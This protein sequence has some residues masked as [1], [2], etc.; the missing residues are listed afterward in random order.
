M[1]FSVPQLDAWSEATTQSAAATPYD[2]VAAPLRSAYDVGP[3]PT[4]SEFAGAAGVIRRQAPGLVWPWVFLNRMVADSSGAQRR[5]GSTGGEALVGFAGVDLDGAGGALGPFLETFRTAL[6]VARMVGAPGIVLDPEAYSD[7]RIY[8]LTALARMRGTDPMTIRAQV[9]AVGS[10]LA[11][12]AGQEFPDVVILALSTKYDRPNPWSGFIPTLIEGLLLRVQSTGVPLTLVD[13]GESVGY[14]ARDL[15]DLR[16]RHEVRR[17]R[18]APV[19]SRFPKHL[20]L[21]GTLAP[22][23]DSA[24]RTGW[25]T[26]QKDCRDSAFRTVDDFAAPLSEL[27]RQYRYVWVYGAS[28]AP[29]DPLSAMDQSTYDPVLR[30]AI[31]TGRR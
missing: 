31:A 16:R 5:A 6:K 26:T 17:E 25:L 15:A 9:D 12:I 10:R 14:C 22:W 23:R 1:S 27:L 3:A 4:V 21:G 19:M 28:A 30:R 7:Y 18:L 24:R 11:D 13:G 29:Y 8:D 2:G 20:V